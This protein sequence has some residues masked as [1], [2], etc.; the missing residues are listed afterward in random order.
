MVDPATEDMP[1][2]D[3][4]ALVKDMDRRLD[5]ERPEP[6][7]PRR[8]VMLELRAHAQAE[9]ARRQDRG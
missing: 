5:G 1:T 4:R 7:G 3:L 8:L 6:R 2:P 9:L